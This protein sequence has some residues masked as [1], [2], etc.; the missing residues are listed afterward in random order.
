MD[1]FEK[2]YELLPCGISVIGLAGSEVCVVY[3]NPAW[4][5]LAGNDEG[6]TKE[7]ML[8]GLLPGGKERWE[9]QICDFFSDHEAIAPIHVK[10]YHP[11]LQEMVDIKLYS[12][13]SGYVICC[14]LLTDTVEDTQEST[15]QRDPMSPEAAYFNLT[16]GNIWIM[17]DASAVTTKTTTKPISL[18][19]YLKLLHI[20]KEDVERVRSSLSVASI[21]SKLKEDETFKLR[22]PS[23]VEEG[24]FEWNEL[25]V[26]MCERTE[27]I[28]SAV[29]LR[30]MNLNL[31][32]NE[33]QRERRK[34][35]DIQRLMEDCFSGF[36]T[37]FY[38]IILVNVNENS[39]M[40]QNPYGDNGAHPIIQP[41]GIYKN[42]N[43]AYGMS[44]VHPENR[45]LFWSYTTL[46]AYEQKLIMEGH[47]EYFRIRHILDN[48]YRWVQVNL[49]RLGAD[50][51]HFRVLYFITDIQ[52]Q[53]DKEEKA[54]QIIEDA[55]RHAHATDEAKSAFFSSMSHDIRT[56]LNAITGMTLLARKHLTDR[57]KLDDYLKKIDLS[58]KLLTAMI[59]EV[60][61]ISALESGKLTL[62]I[63]PFRLKDIVKEMDAL[64]RPQA[65]AKKIDL[66][67]DM[68]QTRHTYLKG[69]PVQLFKLLSNLLTNAVKYT[70]RG[71]H[72]SLKI[73][74]LEQSF[75]DRSMYR[76][77]CRDDGIGMS[78]EFQKKAF[79]PF[80]RESD[81]TVQKIQGTGLGLN[82]IQN[83][84][85]A[86]GGEITLESAK[87]KG[88]VF[89][90]TIGFPVMPEEED[91]PRLQASEEVQQEQGAENILKGCHILM[92]EDLMQTILAVMKNEPVRSAG[93]SC[94]FPYP[95]SLG[96]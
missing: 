9:Y 77:I 11:I 37:V 28:P 29:L 2:Y 31:I 90:V 54:K 3:Q 15:E 39:Y 75:S 89:T 30:S 50:D 19:T 65:A 74:E 17:P 44:F 24:R 46:E 41:D 33:S 4:S 64:I 14:V 92:V 51:D 1:E 27:Q 53:V 49:V 67:M 91:L 34:L 76:F 61:D 95:S 56:P 5:R 12:H 18:D 94:G 40:V 81:E 8:F 68:E 36:G 78:E 45:E 48:E 10:E 32:V 42:D 7:C 52:E 82:I 59:T 47:Y 70:P 79:M 62:E 21:R 55:L 72:V 35:R 6:E 25:W 84:T 86:M 20:R 85:E 87:G 38:N 71:G 43:Y 83:L 16:T 57:E 63:T 66:C 22:L 73:E 60:L 93:G 88:T 96:I 80:G 69:N 23:E 26:S 58:C 13:P